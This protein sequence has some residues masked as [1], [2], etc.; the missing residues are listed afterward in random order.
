MYLGAILLD[1]VNYDISLKIQTPVA[2]GNRSGQIEL[3][4]TEPAEQQ[5]EPPRQLR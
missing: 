2:A 5:Q 1:S 4:G 3:A